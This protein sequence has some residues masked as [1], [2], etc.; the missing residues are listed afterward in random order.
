MFAEG[1]FTAGGEDPDQSDS[2]IRRYAGQ[3]RGADNSS[4]SGRDRGILDSAAQTENREKKIVH[5][6][7]GGFPENPENPQSPADCHIQHGYS[8]QS[9]HEI[10]SGSV[11]GGQA[12]V[13]KKSGGH[14]AEKKENGDSEKSESCAHISLGNFCPEI[15]SE[16]SGV[17]H[18]AVAGQES[19]G[20]DGSALK[21]H[22][23]PNQNI[24]PVELGNGSRA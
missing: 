8:D 17:G 16:T 22:G 13:H 1:F 20:I 23:K 18:E 3:V 19:A 7:I 10:V 4:R 6:D 14:G 12:A 21:S 5:I 24:F 11:P 9:E 2:Q 15:C